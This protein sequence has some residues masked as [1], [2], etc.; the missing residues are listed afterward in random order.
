[1]K[2]A[3]LLRDIF[4]TG[5]G[6]HKLITETGISH[7]LLYFPFHG[8]GT[9]KME[10][11]IEDGANF[12][13]STISPFLPR[14]IIKNDQ[15]VIT[16]LVDNVLSLGSFDEIYIE[17]D[18]NFP[19]SLETEKRLIGAF[20]EKNPK[21]RV[22]IL[23]S[24]Y[25]WLEKCKELL[26]IAPNLF[27]VPII[28]DEKTPLEEIF[29]LFKT[30][31]KNPKPLIVSLTTESKINLP[32]LLGE[33]K[34]YV[35]ETIFWSFFSLRDLNLPVLK[36]VTLKKAQPEN[37]IANIYIATRSVAVREGPSMASGMIANTHVDGSQYEF[38]EI[39]PEIDGFS[40]AKIKDGGWVCFSQNSGIQNFK[41]KIGE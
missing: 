41:K 23:A 10:I 9:E 25:C 32:Y 12:G 33:Y 18:T 11:L 27:P 37:A 22:G 40:W 30:E 35:P 15:K 3:I 39:I 19:D 6:N 26:A 31:L 24:H 29:S 14:A 8:R 16:K 17:P 7:G 21:L 20:L 34:E 13:L 4:S 5:D 2:L 38:E 36:E 1:M 28:N